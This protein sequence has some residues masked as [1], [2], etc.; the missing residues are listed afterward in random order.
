MAK[1]KTI[2]K[3]YKVNYDKKVGGV[4]SVLVKAPKPSLAL[5][6]A[7]RAVATGRNFRN[8]RLVDP[9]T[10]SKP[11]KQGFYGSN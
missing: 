11:R 10:Y 2:S 7:K 5:N 3:V 4:G 6:H 9:K 1:K 8:P